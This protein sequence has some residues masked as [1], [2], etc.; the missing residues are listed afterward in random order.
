MASLAACQGAGSDA[1]HFVCGGSGA[2][3]ARA[4]EPDEDSSLHLLLFKNSSVKMVGPF[5]FMFYF[6]YLLICFIC[7]SMFWYIFYLSIYLFGIFILTCFTLFLFFIFKN[8]PIIHHPSSLKHNALTLSY[9]HRL[10]HDCH[11]IY[12]FIY[13]SNL[14]F[15]FLS[16]IA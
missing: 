10:L 12:Y 15:C 2:A 8:T 13:F 3:R 4:I 14:F 11:F 7:F 16:L 9:H 1:H 6:I 5:I